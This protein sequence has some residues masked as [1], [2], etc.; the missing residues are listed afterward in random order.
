MQHEGLLNKRQVCAW[1]G[2]KPSTLD[3]LLAQGK[4][5]TIRFNRKVLFDPT[6]IREFINAHKKGGKDGI[7]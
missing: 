2:I 1:L 3:K 5:P 4:I 7:A 6:D